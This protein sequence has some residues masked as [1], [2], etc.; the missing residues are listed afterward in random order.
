MDILKLSVTSKVSNHTS[1]PLQLVSQNEEHG[2]DV[3]IN[4]FVKEND[5]GNIN[6]GST[7]PTDNFANVTKRK[8][9][10]RCSLPRITNVPNFVNE[11]RFNDLKIT[12]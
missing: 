3:N 9:K 7:S 10:R 11:N 12:R 4:R 6:T 2:D 8:Q 1:L 5:N